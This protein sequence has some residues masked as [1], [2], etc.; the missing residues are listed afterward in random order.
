MIALTVVLIKGKATG[1]SQFT[2]Q[3]SSEVVKDIHKELLIYSSNLRIQETIEQDTNVFSN[4][5]NVFIQCLYT[6]VMYTY[7]R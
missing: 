6:N 5:P 3:S 7:C 2:V 1:L 4:F